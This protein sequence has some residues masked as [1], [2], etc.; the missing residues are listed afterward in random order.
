[1]TRPSPRAPGC[2]QCSH[3]ERVPPAPLTGGE[4]WAADQLCGLRDRRF[5]LVAIG[6]F[7]L[8][9][10]RRATATR[11][12]RPRLARQAR[13]WIGLGALAVPVAAVLTDE[14]W[15]RGRSH[16]VWWLLCGLML[17][18]HLGMVETV[19]GSPR[20][21]G[22]ADALTLLRAW[23]VAP[24]W[25]RPRPLACAVAGLTDALDGPLARRAAPT[26]AGRDLE[27]LVDA[28]FAGAA[29]HG[30]WRAELV[31]RPALL[32]EGLRIS[33]GVSYGVV[34][35]FLDSE[36]PARSI[37]RAARV[38]SPLRTGA[39]IAAATGRRR[40]A[41]ALLAAVAV[42]STGLT[43]VAL[44]SRRSGRVA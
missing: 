15:P 19:D 29:L 27:G 40:S 11:H 39:L 18:W 20:R 3:A 42:A 24:A 22:A 17:D 44:G 43:W 23:L 13:S 25:E 36:P 8:A 31:A 12:A 41:T 37:T 2:E 38:L 10:Q 21:L 34:S 26:R 4:R 28:C 35:Y 16:L 6:D 33:A 1:M 14:S 32:A 5:S 9:S 30:C 7:L